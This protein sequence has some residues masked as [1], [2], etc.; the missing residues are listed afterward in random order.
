MECSFWLFSECEWGSCFD[1]SGL[2]NGFLQ[3][4]EENVEGKR[5]HSQWISI[6]GLVSF[7]RYSSKIEYLKRLPFDAH[8]HTSSFNL[9]ADAI[10]LRTGAP[11]PN[12][13]P[14]P[15]HTKPHIAYPSMGSTKY[16]NN[17][18]AFE[19]E[20]ILAGLPTSTAGLAII[21]ED[22]R[23]STRKPFRDPMLKT[24][25]NNQRTCNYQKKTTIDKKPNAA[26]VEVSGKFFQEWSI[27]K[28]CKNRTCED[29]F[30]K[31]FCMECMNH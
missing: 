26:V 24:R 6:S 19:R 16:S 5:M 30:G 12:K 15:I 10:A 4:L 7:G 13:K 18:A 29:C 11:S 8:Q 3:G 22:D 9:D 31:G 2:L 27:C 17:K 21:D 1:Q 14:D 20:R 23:I 28:K 25:I